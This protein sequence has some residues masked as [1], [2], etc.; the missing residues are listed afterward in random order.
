MEKLQEL[1]RAN[2]FKKKEELLNKT[3]N[4]ASA[5][6]IRELEILKIDYQLLQDVYFEVLEHYENKHKD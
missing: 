5:Y 4:N 3:P 6:L 1:Q 2:L